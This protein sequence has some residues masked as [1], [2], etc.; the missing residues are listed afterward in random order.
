[1]FGHKGISWEWGLVFV[2]AALF[3]IG[4]ELWK[5]SKRVYLRRMQIGEYARDPE[6]DL[7]SGPF[8]RY[9]TLAMATLTMDVEEKRRAP[10]VATMMA[11][12]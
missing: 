3:F 8:S 12:C 6:E 9:T 2:E 11:V 1:M 5:W 10:T 4:V 7:E